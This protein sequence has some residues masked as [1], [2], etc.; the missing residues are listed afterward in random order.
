VAVPRV[1]ETSKDWKRLGMGWL[2]QKG[3]RHYFSICNI[4]ISDRLTDW[5]KRDPA[6]PNRAED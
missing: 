1:K 4:G 3:V 5:D 6:I 2:V